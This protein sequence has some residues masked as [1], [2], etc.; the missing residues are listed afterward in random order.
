MSDPRP[1][2]L[3]LRLLLAALMTV[4][5]SALAGA[6]AA[7]AK[8][9]VPVAYFS[10]AI[11]EPPPLSLVEVVARDKGLAGAKLAI[12]DNNT[13]GRFLNQNFSLVEKTVPQGGDLRGAASDLIESGV[14]FF[15]ADLTADRLLALADLAEMKG[16]VILNVRAADDA[17]RQRDCRPNIFNIAP[18]YAMKADALAQYLVTKK[19]MK[20]VLISGSNPPDKA[21]ADAIR[22]SAKRYR[23]K[24]VEERVYAFK[25]GSRRTDTGE[26]QIREQMNKLTQR[27]VDYDVLVV[28]DE[29]EVF[30]EYLPYRTWDPRPVVGSQGLI[31]AAW[32]RSLEQWGGTQLQRRFIRRF[33]RW[34]LERDYAGWQAVRAIGEAVARTKAGDSAAIRTYMLSDNFELA[35]FKG[36][37]LTFRKW[38]QQLRQPIL[39]T[40][41]LMLV[42]VSPQAG[43]LHER[44]PLDTL[45]YDKPDSQCRLN[46]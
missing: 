27:L 43:F 14:K 3:L 1:D 37:A 8:L 34:M 19:W 10:E 12:E 33:G 44:T 32:H 22:R 13:T 20:W 15:L 41:P 21:F 7:A 17:L 46:E 40:S 18:S 4:V 30:G 38:N 5:G 2:V 35:A 31:P 16:A 11:A 39:L 25:A 23:A 36:Q 28:A 9:E 24:I 29:S 45:G 6:A 42:S 26:Q